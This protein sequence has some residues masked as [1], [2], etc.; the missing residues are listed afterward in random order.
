MVT[1]DCTTQKA[2]AKS[3][4]MSSVL[5]I[6]FKRRN[7]GKFW[8]KWARWKLRSNFSVQCTH[9]TIAEDDDTSSKEALCSQMDLKTVDVFSLL[10][11]LESTIAKM[12]I[13]FKHHVIHFFFH[14]DF[15]FN[16]WMSIIGNYHYF[17]MKIHAIAFLQAK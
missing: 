8:I 5:Q 15:N 11:A 10:I 4:T 3:Y 9:G 16:T 7:Q 13:V 2:C 12:R 17:A 14:L 6:G 1:N